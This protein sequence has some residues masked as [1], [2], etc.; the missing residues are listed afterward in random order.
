MTPATPTRPTTVNVPAT[1]PVLEKNPE[2]EEDV[3]EGVDETVVPVAKLVNVPVYT[4]TDVSPSG[5]AAGVIATTGGAAD[6]G[7][8]VDL[9]VD[10]DPEG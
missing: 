2:L 6:V 9:D 1:T 3:L 10:V 8:D 5:C 7:V 4:D